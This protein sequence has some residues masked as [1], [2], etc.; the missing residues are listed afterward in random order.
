MSQLEVFQNNWTEVTSLS[1]KAAPECSPGRKPGVK[2]GNEIA[3]EG[4]KNTHD[5]AMKP[6]HSL[7]FV[8]TRA[9]GNL[10][11]AS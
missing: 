10:S 3:L 8:K 7:S 1:R 11:V 9:L 4:G 2:V 5:T 6:G